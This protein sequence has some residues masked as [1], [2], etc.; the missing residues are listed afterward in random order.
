MKLQIPDDVVHRDIAGEA[1]ILN[2]ATGTYFGLDPVGTRIWQLIGELGSTDKVAEAM[3][4]E[5][6]VDDRRIRQDLD[7]LIRQLRDK[8]LVRTDGEE[9]P[10]AR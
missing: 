7:D 1:V 8:G 4:A 5:F 2:L 3:L 6:D 9:A 10:Q